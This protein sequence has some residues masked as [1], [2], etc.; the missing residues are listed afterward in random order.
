MSQIYS[1]PSREEDVYSL[2][3]IE[4]F[5]LSVDDIERDWYPNMAGMDAGW[6]WW[7]CFP[8]CLPEGDPA[9]PFDTEEEAV[10]DAQADSWQFEPEDEVAEDVS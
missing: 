2:P 10:A 1:V 4:T 6:Y 5:Y 7:P 9:G 3:N 8:G